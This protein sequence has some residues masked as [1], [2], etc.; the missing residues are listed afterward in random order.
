MS[1]TLDSAPSQGAYAVYD[2]RVTSYFKSFED[3]ARREKWEEI[4]SLGA[5]ALVIARDS[6]RVLDEA[7]I[8]AQL[9]SI[10]FYQGN[11]RQALIYANRCHGLA[12]VFQDTPLLIKALY[13]ESASFRAL[14]AQQVEDRYLYAQ[15][16]EAGEQAAA[17]YTKKNVENPTLKGK[18]YFNLGAAHADNPSGD[19][20]KALSCYLTAI[21]CFK[22]VGAID[23][24]LRANIRLGKVYLLQKNYSATQAL[25]NE[26]RPQITT[27]RISMHLD[28]LEAQLQYALGEFVDAKKIAEAGLSLAQI[29]GAKEDESRFMTLLK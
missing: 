19:L 6:G 20:N 10:C 17:L 8:S 13:L 5:A 28:Y 3:L 24:L 1:V 22:N 27:Q 16:V 4:L 18:I 25:I 12:P 9:T 11:F 14:A 7:K 21:D 15:A 29:L 26:T 23:D 2:D